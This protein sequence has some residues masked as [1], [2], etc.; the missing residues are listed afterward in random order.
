MAT[1]EAE[2][3][4]AN[5]ISTTATAPANRD[6]D[7]R[8]TTP[9][10]TR[11]TSAQSSAIDSH[12]AVPTETA[13]SPTGTTTPV[14]DA[15]TSSTDLPAETSAASSTAVLNAASSPNGQTLL[16]SPSVTP[17]SATSPSTTF[18]TSAISMATSTSFAITSTADTTTMAQQSPVPS[19]ASIG[20][21]ATNQGATNAPNHGITAGDLA[22]GIIGAALGAALLAAGATYY[23]IMRKSS[24]GKVAGRARRRRT[25]R[26]STRTNEDGHEKAVGIV[27]THAWEQHLPQGED[28]R[29]I[30]TTVKA[31]FDQVQLH[32]EN[33]YI[34]A[35]VHIDSDLAAALSA[36]AT[37]HLPGPI[38][39][40]MA[41]SRSHLPIM[42]HCLAYL[43]AESMS[44]SRE[45]SL[46]PLSY[47]AVVKDSTR[48]NEEKLTTS[49]RQAYNKWRVL[50]AYLQPE[51]LIDPRNKAANEKV[52]SELMQTFAAFSAWEDPALGDTNARAHLEELFRHA[53][54]VA[55]M[56]WSQPSTYDLRWPTVS[57]ETGRTQAL[58]VAPALEKVAD[59]DGVDLRPTQILTRAVLDRS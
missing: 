57:H 24:N 8:T 16:S 19:F 36:L 38:T 39:T 2:L 29:T 33:F 4:S 31:L 43:V 45:L 59:Q 41:S 22:G 46:L 25:H 54:T 34:T 50:T 1:T 37:P 30:Q 6:S 14:T 17:I 12:A 5:T 42:K 3:P 20:N 56:L 48:V 9:T 26:Y 32:I 7:T 13:D 44:G 23:F 49:A 52:I 55:V 27:D 47:R 15:S 11:S 58:L 10:T 28:D 53:S 18:D 21:N 40:I 51:P 35:E